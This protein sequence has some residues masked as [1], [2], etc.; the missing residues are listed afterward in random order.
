MVWNA[1]AKRRESTKDWEITKQNRPA[2]V[3]LAEGI[4]P[5]SKRTSLNTAT[6]ST[7]KPTAKVRAPRRPRSVARTRAS[8][9][10]AQVNSTSSS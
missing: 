9:T 8:N 2:P 6:E 5:R 10:V 3:S 4:S 7:A 1:V